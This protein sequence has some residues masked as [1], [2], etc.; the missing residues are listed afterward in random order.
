MADRE[1]VK[2][3]LEDALGWASEARESG[4]TTEGGS[5][6]LMGPGVYCFLGGTMSDKSTT[7]HD[8]LLQRD[9]T[10]RRDPTRHR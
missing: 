5:F 2:H 10:R 3:D 1:N 8:L 6:V 9:D 4:D 7:I